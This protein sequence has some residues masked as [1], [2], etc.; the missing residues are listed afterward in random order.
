MLEFLKINNVALIKNIEI[1]LSSGFNVILGETGAGKSII[2]DALN[3]VI[4]EKADKTLIRAGEEVMKVTAKFVTT[5]KQALSLLN[6]LGIDCENGEILI[7]RTYTQAGKNDARIN[8]EMISINTLKEVG[9]ALVD[10]YSQNE[11]V[12]L[13]K[14]KNHL[15]I[16]DSYKPFEIKD[17]KEKIESK[18]EELNKVSAEI[19][20]FG[21]SKEN[22]ERQ[23]DILRYQIAEIE[24]SNLQPNEDEELNETLEKLSHSEKILSALTTANQALNSEEN[25]VLDLIKSTIRALSNIECYDN[26]IADLNKVLSNVSLD[27]EDVSENVFSLSEEY[28]FDEAYLDKL[29][30]RRDKINSL[31]KKYGSD[32]DKINQFLIKAKEELNRLENAEENLAIKEREKKNL[33]DETLKLMNEL[34]KVRRKHASEIETKIVDGLAELGILKAKFQVNFFPKTQSIYNLD[35]YSVNCLEDIEFLFSANYGEELKP[36]SKTISGGEMSRFMLVFKNIIAELDGSETLIFDEVDAG[37]SGKVANA[38]ALKI[39]KLSKKYQIIC[40]THL[41]QV[42]SMGDSFYYVSKGQNQERTETQIK[43]LENSEIVEEL[44]LLSYGKVDENSLI[45]AKNMLSQ[46]KQIKLNIE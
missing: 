6:D 43:V 30:L 41:S 24:E 35:S 40:I 11:S 29:V 36:L 7:T 22:R 12:A 44:A 18:I 33:L 21:G 19:K 42:A 13:L 14:Q 16:L 27:L 34:G 2:I 15:S 20:N 28:N 8:G 46:N 45:F 1:N 17:L 32:L 26:K 23:I 9:D 3:F 25:S 10:A 37:I 5:N 38:V 31:K 4:G 39:A